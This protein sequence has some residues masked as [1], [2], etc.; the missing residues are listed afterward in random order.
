MSSIVQKYI[1]DEITRALTRHNVCAD[2]RVRS[3]IES[4]VQ[5]NGTSLSVCDGDRIMRL[6][7]FIFQLR[8]DVRFADEFPT[9]PSRISRHDNKRLRDNF[10]QI[11]DGTVVVE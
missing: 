7:D 5:L 4:R 11:C 1:A 9:P 10:K 6:D 3:E 8:N 2:G